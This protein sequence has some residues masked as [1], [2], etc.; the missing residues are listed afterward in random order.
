MQTIWLQLSNSSIQSINLK[1]VVPS[2]HW[3]LLAWQ[4]HKPTK[5]GK[6]SG[7]T[8][9]KINIW[10]LQYS[11]SISGML[12]ESSKHRVLWH[13]MLHPQWL[14]SLVQ[15]AQNSDSLA[16]YETTVWT[17]GSA[18]YCI[19]IAT[20]IA[21]HCNITNSAISL[22]ARTYVPYDAPLSAAQSC[23]T[24]SATVSS[25]S[26]SPAVQ[27]PHSNLLP[28]LSPNTNTLTSSITAG[29]ALKTGS[30]Y[31][32]KTPACD[33]RCSIYHNVQF[34]IQNKTAILNAI[35]LKYS[36]H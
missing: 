7:Q 35:T 20:F 22:A 34:F 33:D 8:G 6:K 10:K 2:L 25:C 23:E 36:L 28:Q 15:H 16:V 29:L 12:A 17:K 18:D 26:C 31:T 32:F 1:L 9:N 27:T 4:L 3:A 30:V 24:G 5:H 21:H 13:K 14:S 11:R 19:S